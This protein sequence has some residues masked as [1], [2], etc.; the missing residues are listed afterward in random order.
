MRLDFT[1]YE[2]CKPTVLAML[3]LRPLNEEQEKEAILSMLNYNHH[4][5]TYI[6]DHLDKEEVFYVMNKRFFD[7]WSSHV[8]FNSNLERSSFLIKKEEKL[9][10][11]DNASLIEN[12]HSLRLTDVTYG[13]NY[14][15][16][17]RFVFF[18]LSK[19]YSCN[20]VIELKVI[21]YKNDK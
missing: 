13:T 15:I 5:E 14:V 18:P 17:P 1:E 21:S 10:I 4:I 16:V 11:I 8:G 12:M 7:A 20:K 6:Q 2:K 19:W 9:K 3:A